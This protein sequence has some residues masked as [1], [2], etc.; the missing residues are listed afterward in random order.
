MLTTELGLKCCQGPAGQ[1]IKGAQ[2]CVWKE[3]QVKG[4]QLKAREGFCDTEN[5]EQIYL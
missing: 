4:R 1:K 2:A 5:C 3:K